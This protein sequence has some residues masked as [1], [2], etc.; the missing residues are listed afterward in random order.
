MNQ[1]DLIDIEAIKQL[2][3][4][5]FRFLD[6]KRWEDFG[7]IFTD[8]ATM[9]TPADVPDAVTVG[10]AEIVAMVSRG[11]GAAVTVHHG[12]MPEIHIDT[13]TTAHGVWAMEDMLWWE[14]DGPARHMHGYGHYHEDYVKVDGEWRIRVNRLTRLRV[15]VE[16][17]GGGG[18][19]G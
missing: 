9:A 1:A 4:R 16:G 5:Y 14:G 11:V 17:P 3:A 7:Q 12:H 19:S 15:D 2:K 8:D 6:L 10:R 13:P 18:G